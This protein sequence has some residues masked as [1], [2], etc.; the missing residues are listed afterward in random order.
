MS[1]SSTGP[2]DRWFQRPVLRLYLV[3]AVLILCAITA[4]VV[5]LGP[6]PPRVVVMST[7][8]PGS[9]YE[10]AA[11]KYRVILKR[12][13]IDLRLMP[14][15]GGID[16]LRRLNDPRSGVEVGFAQAG[17]TNTT[18]SPELD[19]LGTVFYEPLWIFSRGDFGG[20]W[21]AALRS[22]KVSIGPAGAG[23]RALALKLLALNRFDQSAAQFLP[24]TAVQAGNALLRGEIDV[25]FMVISWDSDVVRRLVA[26]P[27]ITLVN[28]ARADAYV[29]MF[30]FL[31]KLTLPMGA[32]DLA[33]NRP[34]A[35]V[36]LLAT[37]ANLIV[38][39]DLHPAIQYLLL[40][41]A[42]EVH[43][44]PGIFHKSGQFPAAEPTDLPLSKHARH[45]YRT[46]PPFLQRYLPFWLAVLASRALL[47]LIPLMGIAY[48]L[49]A[50]SPALYQW[51]TQRRILQLYTELKSIELAL[52]SGGC[53]TNDALVRLDR[54]EARARL[55]L[56][57]AF[58]NALYTLRS[59]IDL[60]RSRLASAATDPPVSTPP[61]RT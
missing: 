26:S 29:A 56:P 27:E 36:T 45:F 22:K 6:L 50:Y 17:L 55:R 16:N 57:A 12:S 58:A 53:P 48:P 54:L 14:S 35:D 2:T 44:P 11:Q 37:K 49:A 20:S 28:T 34:A 4:S 13:G 59:H 39:R 31:N 18:E 40:E 43:S 41:A 8:T 15:G 9:D 19:S 24:L 51:S 47:L 21:L 10:L 7:G 42:A 25:A 46:G 33:N 30:P 38:R 32:G 61:A 3:A 1:A 5:W 23:S 60:V 52:D